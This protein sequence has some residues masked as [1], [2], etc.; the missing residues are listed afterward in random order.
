MKTFRNPAL[1]LAALGSLFG[2]SALPRLAS[3]PH[4][5]AISVAVSAQPC[6]QLPEIANV[7]LVISNRGQGTFRAYVATVPGPPYTLSW[8]S[9]SV[10]NES[11]PGSKVEWEHGPGGHGPFPQDVLAIG[12]KDS[13][14][15]FAKLYGASNMDRNATYRIQIEDL[16]DQTYLS[17]AF[18]LC[19][20]HAKSEVPSLKKHLPSS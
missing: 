1:C 12:P 7:R 14:T 20:H 4:E 17:N 18:A 11:L 5:V 10:L 8:L 2:C 15:V 13:T 9:Y 19:Q 3:V 16:A 6:E